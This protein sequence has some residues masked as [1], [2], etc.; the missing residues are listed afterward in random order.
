R[1]GRQD[2]CESGERNPEENILRAHVL[3]RCGSAI[4]ILFVRR[5][6]RGS[7]AAT[8]KVRLASQEVA[9]VDQNSLI[10]GKTLF[11]HGGRNGRV[12]TSGKGRGG[13]CGAIASCR[14]FE[15]I[16]S[17]S[18]V[19]R[20]PTYFV[21]GPVGRFRRSLPVVVPSVRCVPL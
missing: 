20:P 18:C 17:L 3:W 21:G 5:S 6:K 8:G 10:G 16:C 19:R 1:D 12:R 15:R 13:S 7:T 9:P 14:R 4:K 11:L 2:R